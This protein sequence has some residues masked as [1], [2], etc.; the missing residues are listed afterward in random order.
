MHTFFLVFS[1]LTFLPAKSARQT[2]IWSFIFA[3]LANGAITRWPWTFQWCKDCSVD[4]SCFWMWF[5]KPHHAP[6]AP[7]CILLVATT[8][9]SKVWGDNLQELFGRPIIIWDNSQQY[10]RKQKGNQWSVFETISHFA[11]ISCLSQHLSTACRSLCLSFLVPLQNGVMWTA[12]GRET[13]DKKWFIIFCRSEAE[14]SATMVLKRPA[15]RKAQ[16][17][18]AVVISIAASWVLTC[19]RDFFFDGGPKGASEKHIEE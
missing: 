10:M 19:M 18:S 13:Y 17:T 12:W 3:S 11:S 15:A 6:L 14:G 1:S 5:F 9:M 7:M 4:L 2:R 16:V 8:V